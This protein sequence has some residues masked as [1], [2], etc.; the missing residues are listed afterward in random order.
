MIIRKPLTL[1]SRLSIFNAV[2]LSGVLLACLILVYFVL[3]TWIYRQ[4]DNS[5]QETT[6]AV[7]Q[8]ISVNKEVGIYKNIV[9]VGELERQRQ[10]VRILDINKHI[11]RHWGPLKEVSEELIHKNG[12]LLDS[13]I[14]EENK[15]EA[16]EHIRVFTIPIISA[17]KVVGYV[18]S[19]Q[20]TESI[21]NM[22]EL[23]MSTLL[24]FAPLTFLIT[25]ISSRWLTGRALAPLTRI[26]ATAERITDQELRTR[27]E[28]PGEDEV[29]RLAASLDHM[30]D[31]LEVA[32][33][34]YRQ[35][36][37]DA[38]HELRTP[39]TIIKGEISLA[40]QKERDND[41]Y[42]DVLVGIDDEIDR[43]IR[44]VEQ[45]L[46]LARADGEKIQVQLTDFNLFDTL[47]PLL[48]QMEVLANTKNQQLTWVIPKKNILND[49]NIVLQILSNLLDNAVKYTQEYGT[50]QVDIEELH[51]LIRIGV[52]D[53]GHGI[54]EKHLEHIFDRFYRVDKGRSREL[55]GTGLGLAIAQKLALLIGGKIKVNS[56]LGKGT[57]FY[58]EVPIDYNNSLKLH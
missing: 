42:K 39:L 25:L 36:T 5:L 7:L 47:S 29:A 14:L 45:L 8:R 40:L 32:F 34:G 48:E 3:Q 10:Y 57:I 41:Y 30:L 46:F 37:G 13:D 26:A 9:N 51:H 22:M 23:L 50:I 4:V 1:R 2:F 21:E 11:Q 58:L 28:I 19:G 49:P 18:Q 27:L 15:S 43:L 17:G 20:S 12:L 24:I 33:E 56:T 6:K 16:D 35:F 53:T 38:S 31:R 55:G 54:S 52:S 44:M